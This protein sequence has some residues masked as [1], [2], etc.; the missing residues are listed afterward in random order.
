MFLRIIIWLTKFTL[1]KMKK[2]VSLP[3]GVGNWQYI[4]Y[5]CLILAVLGVVGLICA[6]AAQYFA[7]WLT[8]FTLKKMKKSVSLP[9]IV[10]STPMKSDA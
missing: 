8:K 1:K 6:V 7:A 4:V 2:S 9:G 10:G 3:D 5:A